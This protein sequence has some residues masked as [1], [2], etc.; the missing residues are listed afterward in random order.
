MSECVVVMLLNEVMMKVPCKLPIDLCSK[1]RLTLLLGI[2]FFNTSRD[3]RVLLPAR[4]SDRAG[5]LLSAYGTPAKT[6]TC[7][8]TETSAQ[9]GIGQ[10]A[11]FGFRNNSDRTRCNLAACSGKPGRG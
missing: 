7:L 10:V 3:P 6:W 11:Q 1:E 2:P 5:P 9:W 4:S 8:G